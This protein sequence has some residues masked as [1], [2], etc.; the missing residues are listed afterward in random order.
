MLDYADEILA[1]GVAILAIFA[2]PLIVRCFWEMGR[3][4]GNGLRTVAA[5]AVVFGCMGVCGL[6]WAPRID[7]MGW[8]VL[9]FGLILLKLALVLVVIFTWQ[10]F[11]TDRRI[12]M[13]MATILIPLVVASLVFD[14]QSAGTVAQI[15]SSSFAFRFG[16]A[17]TALPF[18]WLG[19]ESA[20]KWRHGEWDLWEA[21]SRD[22]GRSRLGAWAVA[23]GA[24]AAECLL[25]FGF[26]FVDPGPW[27]TLIQ[28]ARGVLYVVAAGCIWVA[29]Y[30]PREQGRLG[31]EG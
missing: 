24:F 26:S 7:G 11:R 17:V 9:R 2:L 20:L 3:G 23:S 12:G 14:F 13:V 28:T 21:V 10:G 25:A 5:A 15:D 6:V 18:L 8:I 22:A 30:R 29:F 4:D 31:L 16:Q 27:A 1:G 19:I